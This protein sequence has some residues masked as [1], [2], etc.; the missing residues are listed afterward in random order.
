MEADQF[1][2]GRRITAVLFPVAYSNEWTAH[3][4]FFEKQPDGSW[5]EWQTDPPLG[6]RIAD[7]AEAEEYGLQLCRDCIDRE[8]M[9]KSEKRK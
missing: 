7:K 9:K 5:K 1:Y 8:E 3:G 4:H 6:H 2:K